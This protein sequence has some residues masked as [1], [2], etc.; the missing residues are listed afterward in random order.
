MG[1]YLYRVTA[2]RVVCSD[3]KE[4][5]VAKFAF[6]PWSEWSDGGRKANAKLMLR[7]G[8]YASRKL[9]SEGKLSD[10]ITLGSGTVYGNPYNFGTFLDDP[11]LG[12]ARLPVITGVTAPE[13]KEQ[14]C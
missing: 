13:M 10:R 8:C 11:N 1:M 2:Q 5:N 12:T 7:T 9:A 14:S 6:K 4:A 3:G